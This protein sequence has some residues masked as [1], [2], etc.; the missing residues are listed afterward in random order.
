MRCFKQNTNLFEKLKI[1]LDKLDK[2]WE[3]YLKRHYK[4]FP[5]CQQAV[6]TLGGSHTKYKDKEINKIVGILR[7]NLLF[8]RVDEDF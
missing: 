6:T 1:L 7:I 5:R 2:L 8:L 3:D 4:W